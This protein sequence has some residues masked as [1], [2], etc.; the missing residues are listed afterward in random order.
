MSPAVPDAPDVF[1]YL[2]AASVLDVAI[3][4][5]SESESESEEDEDEED[6]EQAK[7]QQHQRPQWSRSNSKSAL[8]HSLP[9]SPH[10]HGSSS[11]STSSSFHGEDDFAPHPADVD[12][13]RSTSPE[14]SVKDHD[15]DHDDLASDA[16]SVKIAS[17]MAAAQQRQHLH[18][19]ASPSLQRL[20][21][22]T[23]HTPSA[24]LTPRHSSY[25]PQPPYAPQHQHPLSPGRLPTTGYESL[26]MKLS[27]HDADSE[28]GAPIKPIYRKFEALNH[29]V[30]LYTQDELVE[31][32]EALQRIDRADTEARRLERTIV[33]ASRRAGAQQGGELEWHRADVMAKI[34]YKLGQY[35]ESNVLFLCMLG[36]NANTISDQALSSF[37]KTQSLSPA[38]PEDVSNYRTYLQTEQPIAE[39]ETHFL[40]PTDDLVSVY[41]EPP[42]MR[43]PRSSHSPSYAP[44]TYSVDERPSAH[45]TFPPSTSP[46][47]N[48]GLEQSVLPGLAAAIAA[49][50]VVP[51]LT[52]S[53]IDKFLGRLVVTLLVAVG[54]VGALMQSGILARG[55]LFGQEAITCAAIYGGVMIIMAGII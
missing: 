8:V 52:F 4:S 45:S 53:V 41:S 49:S 30:L 1:A 26:A 18:A 35:S 37:N 9:Q 29:R 32:E 31:L 47:P 2:E 50:V 22:S 20:N 42:H 12:T 23:P 19:L 5:G 54:V 7:V 51:I 28:G 55:A 3:A 27:I 25:P 24:M 15:S 16:V 38:D 40:D 36:S 33:P 48:L 46:S 44:S 34:A 39:E 6:E 21:T 10:G 43:A 13:D 11:S 14:R 17:Q